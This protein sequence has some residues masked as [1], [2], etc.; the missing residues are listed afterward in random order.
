MTPARLRTVEEIF[1]AAL[2]QEPAEV[3]ALVEEKCA[4]DESL[5]R[6]VEALLA[7]HRGA[8]NFIETP[9]VT[10]DAGALEDEPADPLIGQSVGHYQVTRRI[11]IGGMG[12]VY[13]AQRAD[14]QFEKLVAIKL[15]KRG[16]DTDAVL[17]HFRDERQILASLDHPN[18][19]RLLDAD[20]TAS[21]LPYF[22]MEYVEGLPIDEYCDAQA[23]SITERLQLFRQVCGAVSYA[24][25]RAVIHRD[26]KPSNIL[27]GSDGVP[28]L[29]DFGIARILQPGEGAAPAAT[30][31]GLRV[32]TPEYAS[33]EQ[34][35]GEAATTVSEVYSLGVVLYRLLTG[36]LPFRLAGESR[37]AMAPA[38]GGTEPPRPSEGSPERLR[39]RLRG[40]LDN[41]V[42]MALRTEPQ[43]RY[44]SVEQLSEDIRRHLESLPVRAR[45]DTIAY[46]GAKFV[47]RNAATTAAA[48]LVFLSLLG[49]FVATTWQAQKA[50]SQEALAQAE[51][52][53]A[54]RRFNDVRQLARSVLFDYHDAIKDL[55]GATAVR[56][57]LVRDGLAYLDRLAGEG[58]SNPDLQRE[59]AAGYERLGDVRGQARTANLGDLPG[60]ME[61]YLKALRIR[62]ALV[63][64][65]PRDVQNRRDLARSYGRIGNRLIET[66]GATRGME[67]LRQ[68]L[69]VYLELAAEQPGSAEIRYDL[70]TAY[71]DLGLALE[72]SGD[73]TGALENHRTAIALREDLLAADPDN[74][75]QRRDL[76]AS[77]VNLGRALV[78]SGDV[79]GG[80]GSNLKGS[81]I[82]EKLLA[83]SPS[84]ADY[85]RLL[86]IGHQNDGDYRAIVHDTRGA[87]ESFGRKLVLDE[88]SLADDPVDVRSRADLAYSCE[89]IGTL[90]AVS[91]EYAQAQSYYRRAL[92]LR[93]QLSADS[94][95]DVYLRYHFIL[96]RAGMAETQARLGE[97]AAA[98]AESSKATALLGEISENRASSPQ[99][100]L[101][102]QVYQRVAA[103]YLALASARDATQGERREHWHAAREMYVRSLGIWQDMQRRGILTGE[104]AS[105][106][107]EVARA[108]AEC[109]AH[110]RKLGPGPSWSG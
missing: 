7:S 22:V 50:R 43:R 39:R 97:R 100:S 35:R 66:A 104:D 79:A 76:A 93:K 49:G 62:E 73:A 23:L 40:D 106:P 88:Q 67:Y 16:M 31:I 54:E 5:R 71:N 103:T 96:T 34:L 52:A 47:R 27:V 19:A 59:L 53:L 87:L 10:L 64:A 15:V 11:G 44:Q 29:L 41:V 89:R 8:E 72:E 109:D 102:G 101:R 78:L 55:P 9:V 69:A 70:A 82:A 17:R 105:K 94:P 68:A 33:P 2:D 75:R 56:E 12:V 37:D 4:G 1:H 81:D 51:K 99:S 21:G 107:G 24:H 46:R 65:S 13:L 92:A 95:E 25:S 32:M 77:Y 108:I 26:L 60:A 98:L 3:A 83:E 58:G 36:R 57:R 63:A 20:S 91:G 38:V 42:L 14:Q 85:R 80:L 6:E 110:L 86:A 74:Q 18:I 30:M 45:P 48:A 28:K 90:L 84:N 61:S